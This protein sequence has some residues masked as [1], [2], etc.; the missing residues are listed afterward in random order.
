[1]FSIVHAHAVTSSAAT[2]L[3]LSPG[4]A[5]VPAG[6]FRYTSQPVGT[7]LIRGLLS[8]CRKHEQVASH[9]LRGTGLCYQ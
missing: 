7:G 5:L 8:V 2:P 1:M 3:A 9:I 4:S 6:R